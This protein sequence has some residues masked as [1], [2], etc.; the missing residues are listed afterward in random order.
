MPKNIFIFIVF[1]MVV[2]SSCSVYE[3]IQL[4]V[5]K[6]AG[7]NLKENISS[8][9]LVNHAVIHKQKDPRTDSLRTDE[10]FYGLAG[11]LSNSPTISF[12]QKNYYYVRKTIDTRFDKLNWD[13]VLS[14]CGDSI[15]AAIVLE[16]Y[17]VTL[18]DP[19]AVEFSSVYG[20][21]TQL[22]VENTSLWRIYYPRTKEIIYE[23]LLK[24]TL[25]WDASS[26]DQGELKYQLPELDEAVNQSCFYSG[27]KLGEH[28]SPSWNTKTRF[29][30]NCE[31]YDFQN[32]II[33]AK[34]NQWDKAIELWKKYPYGKKKRLA[35]YAAYNL[36][37]ASETMDLIDVALEWAAKSYLLK[38]DD[39]VKKY[40]ELLER[41]KSEKQNIIKKIE[42]PNE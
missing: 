14:I 10:Y 1:L 37:I 9:A 42:K 18:N 3:P 21:Y 36:A 39:Y 6:P 4:Q 15:D 26:F 38:K 23:H 30:I 17:Q 22:K 8:V 12:N 41:R 16:N 20:F 34:N 31:Y 28:I 35:A 33:Y 5:L 19:T 32:A 11:V 25:I 24:D 13:Y 29:L 2:A 7:A 27:V 40:I